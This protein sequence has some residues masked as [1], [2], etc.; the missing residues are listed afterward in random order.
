MSDVVALGYLVLKAQSIEEWRTFAADTL[1]LAVSDAAE[2]ALRLR[3]DERAYRIQVH[4]SDENG[5]VAM[6]WEVES[7]SALTEVARRLEQAGFP[8]K[9]DDGELAQARSVTA[10]IATEDP[11]GHPVEVYHGLMIDGSAFASPKGHRFVSDPMGFGHCFISVHDVESAR[12]FYMD[13]LGMRVSDRMQAGPGGDAYFLRCNARHHS[14]GIA[15]MPSVPPQLLHTMFEVDDLDAVGRAYYECVDRVDPLITTLGRHSNDRMFSFYV[16]S[17]SGF[18]VEFGWGGL[19]I[20]E[21][22]YAEKRIDVESF[23]GHRRTPLNY[24]GAEDGHEL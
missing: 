17:P 13:L 3:C 15:A 1:G 14:L 24:R 16:R 2:G 23:W 8:V 18:D 19:Q 9:R 4:P 12:A 22:T 21:S 6:G 20:D 11:S 7:A 10:L 5:V